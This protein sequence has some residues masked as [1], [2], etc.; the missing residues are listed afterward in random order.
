[1]YGEAKQGI[2]SFTP[3]VRLSADTNKNAEGIYVP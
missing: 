2:F 1:M 3:L